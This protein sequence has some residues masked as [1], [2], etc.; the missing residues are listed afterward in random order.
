[1]ML[2]EAEEASYFHSLSDFQFFYRWLLGHFDEKEVEAFEVHDSF[3]P[4]PI[5]DN[6]KSKW[7]TEKA[8]QIV[9]PYFD[10]YSQFA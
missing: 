6:L 7:V 4:H 9:M 2:E 8:L 5:P 3:F 1:M 10:N